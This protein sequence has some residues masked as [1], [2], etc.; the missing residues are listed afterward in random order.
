[1]ARHSR[2]RRG[3]VRRRRKARAPLAVVVGFGREEVNRNLV[4]TN[5]RG[6]GWFLD[7]Q[8]PLDV[9]KDVRIRQIDVGAKKRREDAFKRW[10]LGEGTRMGLDRRRFR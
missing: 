6:L 9:F 1:M 7:R 4:A 10:Q 2:L 3:G 8:H 5:F